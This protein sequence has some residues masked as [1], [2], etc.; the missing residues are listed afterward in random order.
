MSGRWN[1]DWKKP[2]GSGVILGGDWQDAGEKNAHR[3]E[4]SDELVD[5][6][7]GGL[8]DDYS[9]SES[10]SKPRSKSRRKR[11]K[12]DILLPEI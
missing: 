1:E 2:E 3:Q 5:L 10:E 8:A 11:K 4:I 9:E 12:D 6:V 7:I